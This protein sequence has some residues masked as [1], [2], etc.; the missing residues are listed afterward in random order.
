MSCEAG[1]DAQRDSN[2]GVS[3]TVTLDAATNAYNVVIG[4]AGAKGVKSGGYT[5]KVEL[6]SAATVTALS[7]L[8]LTSG[9][10]VAGA[11]ATRS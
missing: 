1:Y 5:L 9:H 10:A 6:T 7:V 8:M 4:V 11:G 2:P 3:E